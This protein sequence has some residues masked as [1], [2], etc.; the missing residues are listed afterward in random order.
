MHGATDILSLKMLVLVYEVT[1]SLL[2]SH[3]DIPEHILMTVHCRFVHSLV[4][5]NTKTR[6]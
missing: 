5:I 2:G 1:S 4:A 3:L 6:C